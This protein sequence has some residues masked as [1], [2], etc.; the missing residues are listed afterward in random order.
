MLLRGLM[1]FQIFFK[2]TE[3]EGELQISNSNLFHQL[4]QMEKRIKKK[5]IPYF[6]LYEML[7]KGIKSNKYSKRGPWKSG[8]SIYTADL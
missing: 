1:K 3:Y 6:E 8:Y 7:F 4:M 5:V 2:K